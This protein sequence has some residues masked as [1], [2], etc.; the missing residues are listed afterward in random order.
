[1]E[2]KALLLFAIIL[3]SLP[4]ISHAQTNMRGWH[5]AGQTWLVWEDTIPYQETY[6]IY[7][8][9]DQVTDISAAEQ[10]GRIFEQDWSG[11]YRPAGPISVIWDSGSHPSGIY[12]CIL[13]AGSEVIRRKIILSH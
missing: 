8:A 5:A 12:I 6:R 13:K 11:S 7:K 10:T 1:M 4:F 2:K 9:S 3:I